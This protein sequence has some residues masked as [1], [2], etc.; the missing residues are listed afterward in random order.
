MNRRT[1]AALAASLSLAGC[2]TAPAP[3]PIVM[4]LAFTM[5]P[6]PY[7]TLAAARADDFPVVVLSDAEIRERCNDDNACAVLIPSTGV[8]VI[9][10]RALVARNADIIAHERAHC[11]G[12]PADHAGGH[13]IV[14]MIGGGL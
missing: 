6:E 10:V 5:P 14:T 7:A 13:A 8:C 1:I 11:V 4:G 2:M 12:W 3:S 9:F